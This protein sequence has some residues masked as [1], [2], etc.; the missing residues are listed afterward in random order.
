MRRTTQAALAG[1]AM[2]AAA[3]GAP[4]L[5]QTTLTF[6]TWQVEDPGFGD[7]W[8]ELIAAYEAKYPGVKVDMQ[9]IPFKD[10]A[11]Q[12]TIRFAANRA[13]DIVELPS[14]SFGAFV[15][16]DWLA[17]LDA[18]IKGTAI[19]KQ[20]SSLQSDLVWDGKNYGVLVM[21]YG[22]MLF[23]NEALLQ[24]AGAAPPKSFEEFRQA[25]AKVTDRDRGIFG[26]AAVTT[27]HP[28]IAQDFIRFI[29]WA[30][31]DPIVGDKYRFTDPAVVK[32][33]E[34]YRETVGKNAPL[35]N[36]S[37]LARQL[38]VD[39]KA[40]FLIDGPWV[41]TWLDKAPAAVRPQLK[42]IAAPFTPPL[43]GAANSL[44]IPAN[45]SKQKR[46]LVW[47]FIELAATPEWQQ[48]YTVL[49]NSPAG[50]RGALTPAAAQQHPHLRAIND[51]VVGAQPILP[52][53]QPVRANSNEFEAIIRRSALRVLSTQEPVAKIMAELQ[54]ELESTVPLN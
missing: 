16:Q 52:S 51:A 2:L 40:G 45:A 24:G 44:H 15:S 19:E 11:D 22:F 9:Q 43:G 41:F 50:L 42:M 47:K 7:W 1:L 48:R 6:P 54:K 39:G 5:G 31:Q 23:Y 33:V 20:W 18:D 25:V 37:T 34:N 38:F 32:A 27:E 46:D 53:E 30:G 3:G 8:R 49:T 35:G 29:V 28:T 26:L 36:N 10:F 17:P 4:A 13:P 12:L 14:S 21:G